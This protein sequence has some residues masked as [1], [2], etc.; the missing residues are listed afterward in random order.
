MRDPL[1]KLVA[2]LLGA[3]LVAIFGWLGAGALRDAMTFG[4][5]PLQTD[6]RG[7]VHASTAGRQWVEVHAD[8]RCDELVH[9][10]EGGAAFLP[11]VV[12]DSVV[13]ARFD[14]DI[15]C[16]TESRHALTGI[17]EP[18]EAKRAADLG[19]AG[20]SLPEGA[21]LRTLDVC[22]SCGKDNARIGVIVRTFLVLLGFA[23]YP[24][25]RAYLSFSARTHAR[26][27]GAIHATPEHADPANRV[28]RT[29]GAAA[30]LAG[31][32]AA[33]VGRDWV[34]Y[35]IVPVPWVGVIAIVL[36]GWMIAS[37]ESYRRVARRGHRS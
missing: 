34:V 32:L 11:A 12:D 23:L 21:Q 26:L 16:E 7:A 25:R 29:W 15:H 5:A 28:V 13:V 33:A 3:A 17:V 31:A 1:G 30:L 36:G 20:L 10:V 37:P 18:M 24:L 8:W 4:D 19:H 27:Y 6:V 9:H 22:T 14:H 35:R 2:G